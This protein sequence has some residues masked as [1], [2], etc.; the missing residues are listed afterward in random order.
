LRHA[1]VDEEFDAGDVGV[2]VRR[3]EYR[4]L[5]KIVRHAQASE[6]DGGGAAAF[7]S[8]VINWAMPGVSV[9]PGL[10]TLTRMSRPLR[11]T[12]SKP[13]TVFESG[14]ILTYL[15]EKIGRFLPKDLRCRKTVTSYAPVLGWRR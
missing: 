14:A 11:S 12:D 3:E 4:R 5:S 1:A 7:T 8:S 9:S 2:V 13:V 6:R 15:A 10:N